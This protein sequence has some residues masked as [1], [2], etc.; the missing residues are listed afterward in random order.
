M[1]TFDIAQNLLTTFEP[2]RGLSLYM[3]FSKYEED[4]RKELQLNTE[5]MIIWEKERLFLVEGLIKP[6]LWAQSHWLHPKRETITS[7]GSAQKLLR[8][9]FPRWSLCSVDSHR[10]CQLIQQQLK[11]P[12]TPTLEF[13]KP[14]EPTTLGAWTLEDSKTLWYSTQIINNNLP[15]GEVHFAEDKINPPSRAYLKLW[16]LFTVHGIRPDRGQRVLDMGSCPGGW[17]WVLQKSGCHVISVDKAP[18]AESVAQLPN[19]EMLKRDAFTLR[20]EDVGPVDWF[21]SDIICYPEKLFEL[22][23][24]WINSGRCSRFVCTI[25][26]QGESDFAALQKFAGIPNSRLVHLYVNKHEVTWLCGI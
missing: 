12:K 18:L 13:L 5:A 14:Y 8:Q 7:I 6:A 4:L 20:P 16:E 22:V 26:F 2:Y 11:S 17:T 9:K 15:L 23:E 10:R 19:V 24:K 1:R 3:S 25:K 21:F